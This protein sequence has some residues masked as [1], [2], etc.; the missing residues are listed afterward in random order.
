MQCCVCGSAN[1]ECREAVAALA[2]YVVLKAPD[3]ADFRSLAVEC[4][5]QLTADLPMADRTNFVVFAARLSRTAKV[6]TEAQLPSYCI[7]NHCNH[8]LP[9]C[10]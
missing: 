6:R 3:K 2:R 10:V 7:K 1:L 9:E 4:A 5:M 8:C